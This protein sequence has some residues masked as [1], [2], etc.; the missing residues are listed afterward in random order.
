MNRSLKLIVGLGNPGREYQNTR[1]N[2]GFTIIDELVKKLD[3]DLNKK[4]FNGLYYQ[5]TSFIL[6][7]PQTYMNNSGECIKEFLRY[8]SIS[9]DNLLVIYDDITLPLG[10]FRYRLSGSAGGHNGVRNIIELLGSEK[11]KRLRLGVGYDNKILIKDW[12]LGNFSSLEKREL[13]KI[14]PELLKSSME[15]LKGDSFEKLMAK[16]NGNKNN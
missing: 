10:S 5:G 8:F 15:W 11:F 2:L 1:H 16:F 6:L 9:I 4:K 13:E 3:I 12:V 7:K 14:T